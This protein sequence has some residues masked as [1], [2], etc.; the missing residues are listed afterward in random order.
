MVGE[1]GGGA[2]LIPYLIAVFLF[3][4][5]LMMLEF[6]LGNKYGIDCSNPVTALHMVRS[7]DPYNGCAVHV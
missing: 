7:F 6:A 3:D 5:P 4:L 2:F 1:N